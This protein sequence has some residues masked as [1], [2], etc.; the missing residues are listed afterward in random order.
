MGIYHAVSEAY[1][2]VAGDYIFF[3]GEEALPGAPADHIGIVLYV[4]G[5]TVWTVEGNSIYQSVAVRSYRMDDPYIVGYASPAYPVNADAAIDFNPETAGYRLW[6]ANYFITATNLNVR[7]GAGVGHDVLGYLRYG[8]TVVLLQLEGNWGRIHYEGGDGWISLSYV[9][10]VPTPV[11][12][13]PPSAMLTLQVGANAPACTIYDL[14]TEL[15]LPELPERVSASPDTYRWVGQGWDADGDGVSDYPA[16]TTLTMQQDLTLSAV[17]RREPT[18]Y[19]VRFFGADGVL[20]SEQVCPYGSLPE[21]PDMAQH[22]P[23]D[24]RIFDGWDGAVLAVTQDAEYHAVYLPPPPPP[25][26]TVRFFDREGAMIDVQ[27]L[28]AGALPVP[29][30]AQQ[31]LYDDGSEFLGW[32][33]EIVPVVG[34]ADYRA[35]YRYQ[36]IEPDDPLPSEPER[37]RQ[38]PP[39]VVVLLSVGGVLLLIVAVAFAIR[40]AGLTPFWEKG[41]KNPKNF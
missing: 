27:L 31:M 2:P 33:E 25:Q 10:Y 8:D 28:P 18:T 22:A 6:N 21:Q 1:T 11:T 14:G 7:A 32:D 16:G 39:A 3:R 34:D 30:D 26:Y 17:Y 36:A 12:A 41:F 37:E 19:T 20:I 9:Q 23:E 13:R 15:T 29:P 5:K 4:Q 40:S 24:G 38:A 35:V